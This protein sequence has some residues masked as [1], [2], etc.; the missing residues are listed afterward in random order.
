M[1]GMKHLL[2]A[3]YTWQAPWLR[4]CHFKGTKSL[5]KD[6]K[7]LEF[8]DEICDDFMT[9][10]RDVQ[11]LYSWAIFYFYL[12]DSKGVSS[13][14]WLLIP[15]FW[16][17]GLKRS[18][19][20]F[21]LLK[22][23]LN[24]PQAKSVEFPNWRPSLVKVLSR[25]L[26][27]FCLQVLSEERVM[28]RRWGV[29]PPKLT[30]ESPPP[31]WGAVALREQDSSWDARLSLLIWC[32]NRAGADR[33]ASAN[34]SRWPFNPTVH[35]SPRLYKKMRWNSKEIIILYAPRFG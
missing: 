26:L 12:F 1:P 9:K 31:I 13:F 33:W 35:H 2:P 27:R 23:S 11:A 3:V 17:E 14:L 32:V 15:L 5:S 18:L 10:S 28:N 6:A 30:S 22:L 7:N 19:S 29:E 8:H 4:L 21:H 20:S 16:R 34:R 25:H 24:L